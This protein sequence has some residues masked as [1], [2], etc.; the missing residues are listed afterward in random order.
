[1]TTKNTKNIGGTEKDAFHRYKRPELKTKVEKPGTNGVKTVIENMSA[2]AKALRVPP[3]YP[4]RFLGYELCTQATYEDSSDRTCTVVKGKHTEKDLDKA[5][6]EF[7]KKFVLCPRC[8]LP[9]T[10]ISVKKGQVRINCAGCGHA[11][12]LATGHRLENY[13]SK[14]PPN[15]KKS[16]DGS[17]EK[18]VDEDEKQ[19][20]KKSIEEPEKKDEEENW[21]LD[22]SVEARKARRAEFLAA[23][24]VNT[25]RSTGAT[26]DAKPE[27]VL[28]LFMKSKTEAIAIA[29]ELDRLQLKHGL[30]PEERYRILLLASIDL[31]T[32]KTLASQFAKQASL[33][34]RVV[35]G[36]NAGVLFITSI[37]R[38]LDSV[39]PSPSDSQEQ[40]EGRAKHQ[41]DTKTNLISR[42]GL[43][44]QK[45]YEGD[46]LPEEAIL[47]WAQSPPDASAWVVGRDVATQSR[48]CANPFV[49]WLQSAEE[50]ED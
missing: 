33:F 13:I 2:I 43:V 19:E 45:L 31:S 20:E 10:K 15:Q 30:S 25:G 3:E 11:G 26:D 4:T 48:K 38:L 50:D 6:D 21:S 47:A 32:P 5:L 29:A 18:K 39:S 24:L 7:I 46:V 12:P 14:N 35:K 40:A 36:Q 37:E 17:K 8:K 22:T 42:I 28:K 27:T 16:Q 23:Q 41:E 34:K 9:E 1:M 44:L 49:E